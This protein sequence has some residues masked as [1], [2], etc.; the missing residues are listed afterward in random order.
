M[1]EPACG[2]PPVGARLW[3]PALR[4]KQRGGRRPLQAPTCVVARKAGSYSKS[5]T[6]ST[7]RNSEPCFVGS[8]VS[9]RV[10]VTNISTPNFCALCSTG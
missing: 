2:S 9:G 1:Q 7:P 8:E 6:P 10:T 5:F 3:E 4:A